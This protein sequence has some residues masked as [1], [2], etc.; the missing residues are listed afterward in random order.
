MSVAC[1]QRWL[2]NRI[3]K[4]DASYCFNPVVYDMQELMYREQ[5]SPILTL[6]CM[7]QELMTNIVGDISTVLTLFCMVKYWMN[8]IVGD[9][10]RFHIVLCGNRSW[11]T[12]SGAL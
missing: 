11:W 7:V 9:V 1:T 4:R 8:H 2:G 5:R 10:Y 6:L 3:G 12:V